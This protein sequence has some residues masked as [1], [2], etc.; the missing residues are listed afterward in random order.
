VQNQA[1]AHPTLK[2]MMGL[3]C[4]Q[5]CGIASSCLLSLCGIYQLHKIFLL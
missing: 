4:R 2:R 3:S 5:T 1:T